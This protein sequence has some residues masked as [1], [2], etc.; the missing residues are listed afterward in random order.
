M[1]DQIVTETTGTKQALA[2]IIAVNGPNREWGIHRVEVVLQLWDYR[3]VI[4]K[5][6]GGNCRGLSIIG[7][8]I[9][10]IVDDMEASGGTVLVSPAGDELTV[11]EYGVDRGWDVEV[12]KMIVSARIIEYLPPT[13]N[14]VRARNGA[15]PVPDGDRPLDRDADDVADRAALAK[16]EGT[17]NG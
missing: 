7:S 14:E 1:A 3:K 15:G 17:A 11:D 9:E 6:V 10:S 13:L 16:A 5:E 4:V 2:D 12:E 8:A